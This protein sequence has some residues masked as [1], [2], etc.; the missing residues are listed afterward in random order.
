MTFVLWLTLLVG[1]ITLVNIGYNNDFL[2]IFEV[3]FR[4]GSITF[5]G[6]EV[7]LPM[8]QNEAVPLG[9]VTDEQFFQGLGL[10][11][12]LP[13]P[14]FNFSSFLGATYKGVLGAIVAELGLFG[15]GYILIFTMVPYW[16][17]VRHSTT[18]KAILK[19]VNATAVGLIGSGCVFLYARAVKT[20]ADAMVFVIAG[21]LTCF[22]SAPAPVV[23]LLGA[24]CGSLFSPAFLDVGQ[25][26]YH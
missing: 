6:A 5:G 18:F 11:Q 23:V 4:I 26:K 7:A 9:W 24:I 8:L 12:S 2:K 16:G 10:A 15:P 14:L 13:G 22:Y 25:I 3:M 21:G 17:Q 1:S 19:G 20:A